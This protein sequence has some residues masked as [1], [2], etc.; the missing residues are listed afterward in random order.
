LVKNLKILLIPFKLEQLIL[1]NARINCQKQYNMY[2][3]LLLLYYL[4]EYIFIRLYVQDSFLTN[5][6]LRSIDLGYGI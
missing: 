3:H 6:V 5:Q 2:F 1:A 4:F